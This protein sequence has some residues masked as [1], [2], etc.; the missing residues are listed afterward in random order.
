MQFASSNSKTAMSPSNSSSYSATDSGQ[1]KRSSFVDVGVVTRA[2][3][4]V[5][6]LYVL[7]GT[8]HAQ[9]GVYRCTN[10][11]GK[12][13]YQAQPCSGAGA[14]QGK[15]L[16]FSTRTLPSNTEVR[17]QPGRPEPRVL[18]PN[19][20]QPE[21]KRWGAE[22]DV[23]VVSGYE[24]SSSVTKVHINHSARPVLLVLTSYGHTEWKVLP[25]P[26]TLIKAVVVSDHDD[27]SKVQAPP[28]VP[29]VVDDLPDASD[30]ASLDFR[31]LI[32]KLHARYGVERVL[33]FRGGYKLPELV[34]VSGPFLPDPQLT[35]DGLR[36]EAPRIRFSFDLISTDGRRL[37]WTNTGPKDGKR[38]TG[39]VRGGTLGSMGGGPAVVREDGGEAYYLKGNGGTLMWAPQGFGGPEQELVLPPHLPRLSWGS[40]LAWDTRK[41]VL[42]MVSFGGEGYFYRYDTRN[43]KWLEARQLQR[44][45]DLNALSWNAQTGGFVGITNTAELVTFNERGELEDAQ[46][47]EKLLTDLDSTY[48]KGNSRMD[49]LA[50]AANGNAV[51]VVNVRKGTVTHI[52]TYEPAS[53]KAQLTYKV[54]E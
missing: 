20:A 9:G 19:N 35:L 43:R 48:D 24:L 52:W 44:S 51:A 5:C 39:I 42:A 53:R 23:I 14:A 38:Y 46:P 22:A 8:A 30:T 13:S 26:G 37:P 33:G 4:S 2:L 32:S 27:R 28:K 18:E 11:E 34:P 1:A 10:V 17:A 41:G 16:P 7:L 36:P 3:A 31:K 49:G 25:A 21:A 45:R 29:V 6:A 50:V 12:V 47:L 40:G 54:V 15:A